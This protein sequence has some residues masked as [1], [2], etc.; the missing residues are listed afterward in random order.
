MRGGVLG[1]AHD[2]ARAGIELE[3]AWKQLHARAHKVKALPV[4]DCFKC[5]L[6]IATQSDIIAAPYKNIALATA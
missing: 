5:L 2:S 4:V 1:G 3:Y 6:G